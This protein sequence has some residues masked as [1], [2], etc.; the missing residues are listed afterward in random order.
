MNSLTIAFIVIL[1]TL[2]SARWADEITKTDH[3][4]E[5]E[6][7]GA[8]L[9]N[10][11][12]GL[13]GGIPATAAL[14]RTVIN[15]K[16]GATCRV[17]GI[18]AAIFLICIVSLILPL[19]H[20]LPLPTV[21]ALLLVVAYKMIEKEHIEYLYRYDIKMFFVFCFTFFT[22]LILNTS[23]SL[24]LGSLISLILYAKD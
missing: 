16:S 6:V 3:N 13:F 11:I 20:F 9:S 22:C 23:A 2:I 7:F 19:F 15:I 12:V 8:S 21:A 18:L 14:A 24:V 5:K 17:S 10:I 1:E 4:R